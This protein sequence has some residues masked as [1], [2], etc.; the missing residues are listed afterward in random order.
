MMT[1][2]MAMGLRSF[3]ALPVEKNGGV[4]RLFYQRTTDT[5]M[6]ATSAA[7]GLSAEQTL[8][9]GLSYLSSG[10]NNRRGDTSVLYRHIFWKDDSLA[11][12]NRLGF[13]GGVIIP[14][15]KDQKVTPQ[16]GL[17]F[18]HF[19][20]RYEIDF[21]TLYQASTKNRTANARYDLS[22][23]YR[24]SP[25]V[26]PDWGLA[27]EL[28]SVLE[29]NGNWSE[30]NNTTHQITGGLQWVSAEWIIEGGLVKDL[31]NQYELR[32]VLSTRFHF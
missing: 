9:L 11:G 29:L 12:T 14:E 7:Y 18:T 24:L 30:G 13:L 15:D 17:V 4:I 21:D 25:A 27:T 8:L 19:K 2:P 31:N 10:E 22:W 23:Q 20:D 26:R 6:F 16:A 32:S 3:V 1:E 28:N 5:D